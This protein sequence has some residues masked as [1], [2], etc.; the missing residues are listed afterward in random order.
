MSAFQITS[1]SILGQVDDV[2]AHNEFPLNEI[3]R[4]PAK[5]AA[6]NLA[7]LG[8]VFVVIVSHTSVVSFANQGEG[9][10]ETCPHRKQGQLLAHNHGPKISQ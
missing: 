10:A 3:E 8:S 6:H 9:S 5:N 1:G 4:Q 2:P 7:E